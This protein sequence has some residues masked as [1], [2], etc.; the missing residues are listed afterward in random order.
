MKTQI[1][2]EARDAAQQEARKVMDAAK[3]SIEQ[4]R[5]QAE[6]QFR[7][8][9]STFALE[10]AGKVVRGQMTDQKAQAKLVDSLL[11]EMEKQ[12]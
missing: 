4:E 1:I 11:D 8:E 3:V 7:N 5:K 10:I 12:N 9:V 6:L 2:E